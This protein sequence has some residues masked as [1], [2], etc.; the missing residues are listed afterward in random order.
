MW[1][2]KQRAAAA[3][4]AMRGCEITDVWHILA[5]LSTR[6]AC[7][8][9]AITFD[10]AVK[11]PAHSMLARPPCSACVL[12]PP[13]PSIAADYQKMYSIGVYG[14]FQY[15]LQ[16]K[17]SLIPPQFVAAFADPVNEV[18]GWAGGWRQPAS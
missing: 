8:S 4:T 11:M 18:G 13:V 17:P 1:A 15:V 16:A 7:C 10:A 12:T 5:H 2:A 6:G 14:L 3:A 9:S